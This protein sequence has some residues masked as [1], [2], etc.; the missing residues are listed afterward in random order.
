MT[1]GL[2]RLVYLMACAMLLAAAAC[3][4]KSDPVTPLPPGDAMP[5]FS[6]PDVNPNSATSGQPVSPR[7]QLGS[8]SGWYFGHST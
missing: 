2:K 6:L 5:D 7:Q 3:D 8:I 4:K 1:Q